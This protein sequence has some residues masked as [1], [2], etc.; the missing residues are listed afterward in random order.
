MK[1]LIISILILSVIAGIAWLFLRDTSTPAGSTLTPSGSPFGSGDD[2][3][4][5]V[6]SNDGSVGIT[7]QFDESSAAA[8]IFRISNTPIAGFTTFNR[9]ADTVVR[10]VDRGTGHISDAI[11]QA[12]STGPIEKIRI[13]NTTLPKIQ[14]AYFRDDASMVLLRSLKSGSDAVDNMTL[15]LTPPKATS[16]SEFYSVSATNL[17]GDIESPAA[18]AGNTLYY[19]LKDTGAIV[20]SSFTGSDLKTLFTSSFNNW[21]LSRLG[22]SLLVYSKASSDSSG[23]AYSLS[24]GLIKLVGPLNGLTAVG[25]ADSKK[26]IYSYFENGSTKLFVKDIASGGAV[27][28]LPATLAEKCAWSTKSPATVVCGVPIINIA[29]KEPEGWYQGKTHFTDY[30]WKFDT[31]SEIAQLIAEPKAGFN[32]DLDVYS[33][34]LSSNDELFIFINKRDMTLWAVR[35]N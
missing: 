1:K 5:P 32:V 10:F 13:T 35:A 17:R 22:S 7:T 15:T 33:P 28:F 4:I 11:I 14:E 20:S 19:V 12:S 16:T 34:R 24:A 31:N 30:I 23:S 25:S 8:R 29:S 26:V 6:Q 21:R 3:N 9:G 18:G 27:E 2:I